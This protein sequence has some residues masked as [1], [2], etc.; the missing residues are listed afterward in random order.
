MARFG[1]VDLLEDLLTQSD[2][3]HLML[4]GAYRDNEVNS[5]P[6][7]RKLR[8]IRQAGANVQEI[9]LAPLAVEDL[10]R[11]L[12]DSVHCEPECTTPLAQLIHQKTA[13]IRF[14]PF[15]LFQ[16]LPKRVC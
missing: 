16:H 13:A 1:N 15:S 10:E 7:I 8:A 6:L 12:A 5:H 3:Q 9:V 4:I 2:V 11:L 14:S